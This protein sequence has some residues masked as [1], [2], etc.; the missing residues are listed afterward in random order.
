M[1]PN[2]VGGSEVASNAI[3]SDEVAP[4]TLAAADLAPNSVGASETADNSIGSAEVFLDSLGAVDLATNSV[5]TAEIGVRT[6]TSLLPA[7]IS[8]TV[9]SPPLKT[10]TLRPAAATAAGLRLLGVS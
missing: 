7:S 1:A 4:D 9:E 2:S 3:G 6:R 5:G 10:Q 8:E